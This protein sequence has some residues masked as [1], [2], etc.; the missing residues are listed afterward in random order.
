[1]RHFWSFF[2]MAVFLFSAAQAPGQYPPVPGG[3]GGA[4]SSAPSPGALSEMQNP[5]L[6]GVPSGENQAGELPLSLKDAIDRG[7]KY[8][9]GV[10]LSSQSE[11]SAKA[12]RLRT[13]SD[14]LPNITTQTSETSQ[15]INLAAYGFP[16][17]PGIAPIVGPFSVFDTRAFL[18]QTILDF[19]AFHN[20]RAGEENE[21]AAALDYRDEREQV[22]LI[23]ADLYLLA[24]ADESR[25][26]A[27]ESQLKTAQALYDKAVNMKSAG[28]VPGIDVLRARVEL[29]SYRQ[30]RLATENEFAKQKLTL[31]RAIGLPLG[32]QFRLTSRVPYTPIAEMNLD[33][34][35]EDAYRNRAD[36]QSAMERVRAAESAVKAAR[37]EALPRVTLDANYG[38]IGFRPNSSHGTY[39]VAGNLQIPIFQGGRVHANTLAAQAALEQRKA[40]LAD[41]KASIDSEVRK[42]FLDWKSTD[43]QVQVAKTALDL[44]NEELKQSQDRFAA[45]VVDNL[46]VVQAQ[47][48]VSE[49]NESYISTLY[50]NDV[51]KASLARAIGNAEQVANEF[52]K[53]DK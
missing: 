2:A 25:V 5:L 30:R 47:A 35:L 13:L 15:Q 48:A 31:A 42:S 50:A 7:L 46:E 37:G 27:A 53:G 40:E 9:L 17:F 51:A 6:G 14:L 1:M 3:E 34:A 22:V 44:A 39:S 33:A 8:N 24:V 38:D 20:Y 49:A 10:I 23:C 12:A 16:S 11:R 4:E 19:K 32:Q 28:V 41:L 52:L 26:E 43:A 45:G 36:Y 29:E 18:S 21:K